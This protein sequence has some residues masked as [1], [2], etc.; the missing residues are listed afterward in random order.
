[1]PRDL[2]MEAVSSSRG[3]FSSPAKAVTASWSILMPMNP[4]RNSRLQ[5]MDSRLK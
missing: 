3:A 2:Q 4:V 1:M 5:G